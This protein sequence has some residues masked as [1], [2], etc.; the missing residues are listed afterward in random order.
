[1]MTVRLKEG[2]RTNHKSALIFYLI[3]VGMSNKRHKKIF[4][5]IP[6]ESN[7]Y[8]HIDSDSKDYGGN[9]AT[10]WGAGIERYPLIAKILHRSPEMLNLLKDVQKDVSKGKCISVRTVDAINK[11]IKE[12]EGE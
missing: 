10:I 12:I 2:L 1:M 5:N 6:S 3:E 8:V 4:I 11:I 9:I 7:G